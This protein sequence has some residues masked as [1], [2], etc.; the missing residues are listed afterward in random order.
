M[1]INENKIRRVLGDGLVLR[2]ATEAERDKVIDFQVSIFGEEGRLEIKCLLD[3][4]FPGFSMESFLIVVDENERILSSLCFIECNWRVGQTVL[5]MGMPEFVGTLEEY[6]GKGLVRVQFEILNQ[7]MR[8]RNIIFSF[9]NGIRYYYRLY[10]YEYA[11]NA[12][13]AGRIRA[14]NYRERLQIPPGVEVRQARAEDVPAMI[15]LN[16]AINEKLDV[17][18]EVP[19]WDWEWAVANRRMDTTGNEYWVAVQ[20]GK[21]LGSAYI[22]EHGLNTLL[23]RF[24]GSPIAAISILAK[25]LE[26]PETQIVRLGAD[27]ESEIGQYLIQELKPER[28]PHYAFYVRINDMTQ[29]FQLMAGE[30][31]RRLA[32]SKLAGLTRELVI[33]SYRFVVTLAFEEGKLKDV[34][35]KPGGKSSPVEIAPDLWGKLFFGYRELEQLA[36]LYPDFFATAEDWELLKILFPRLRSNVRFVI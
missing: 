17:V 12:Y 22:G 23:E 11:V 26:S 34:Q 10:G 29:A 5:K 27:P 15:A 9:I 7:W 28:Q 13:R 8:E 25:V 4:P 31:E 30:F 20:D 36:D 24:T 6:R 16:N 3:T 2:Q 18:Y 33:N 35:V 14:E 32:S 19:D 1:S 21:L